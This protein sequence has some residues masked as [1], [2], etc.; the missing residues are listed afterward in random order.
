MELLNQTVRVNFNLHTHDWSIKTKQG[1]RW[2]LALKTPALVLTNAIPIESVKGAERIRQGAHRSVVAK[3]QGELESIG[4]YQGSTGERIR[5]NPT[6]SSHFHY[7]SGAQWFGA[8][9]VVFL[10]TGPNPPK[11]GGA[12]C[13][14]A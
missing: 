10:K 14:E 13:R 3:I 12:D 4:T 5:Y 8:D 6:R 1:G 9:R 7:E 11:Y 2:I